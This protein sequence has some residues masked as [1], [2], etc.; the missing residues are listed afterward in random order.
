MPNASGEEQIQPTEHLRQYLAVV[1]RIFLRFESERKLD[2]FI[3]EQTQK[4]N[5]KK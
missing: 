5:T 4:Q 2:D 1:H 3:E